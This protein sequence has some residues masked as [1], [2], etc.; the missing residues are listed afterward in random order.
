MLYLGVI[1]YNMVWWGDMNSIYQGFVLKVETHERIHN[2]SFS[3]GSMAAANSTSGGFGIFCVIFQ[4]PLKTIIFA[5]FV[6]I[7]N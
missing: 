2:P 4:L 6:E 1:R 5:V 3:D 7:S